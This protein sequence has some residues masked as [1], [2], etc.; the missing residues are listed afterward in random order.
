MKITGLA[1]SAPARTGPPN[2]STSISASSAYRPSR[3]ALAYGPLP[4]AEVVEVF[5]EDHPGKEHLDTGPGVGFVVEDLP[6]AVSALRRHRSNCSVNRAS[7]WLQFRGP[8][9]NVYQLT[10]AQSEPPRGDVT[11]S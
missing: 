9:G 6:A 3:A 5:A 7:R 4:D 11:T 1:G 8:D 10:L 2:S